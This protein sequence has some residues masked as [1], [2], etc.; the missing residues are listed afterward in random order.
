MDSSP[1]L[2]DDIW[3]DYFSHLSLN[4]N[5]NIEKE[6]Q[7]CK[8][9]KN[10]TLYTINGDIFLENNSNLSRIYPNDIIYS[11]QLVNG[12][13]PENLLT[14]NV[15]KLL[16][17]NKMENVGMKILN[18]NNNNILFVNTW[19]KSSILNHDEYDISSSIISYK[20]LIST[21]NFNFNCSLSFVIDNPKQLI[22][23]KYNFIDNLKKDIKQIDEETIF[24]FNF[25]P[26]SLPYNIEILNNFIINLSVNNKIILSYYNHLFEGNKNIK[27]IDKDYGITPIPSCKNLLDIWDIAIKCKKIII[28][29]SG[30]SWTFLHKLKEIKSDQIY[31]FNDTN[32]YKILNNCINTLTEENKNLINF[33]R[34]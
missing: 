12:D 29:P 22:E 4:D 5:K 6:I 14:N 34:F 11:N 13:P 31:M 24:I 21:I 1:E 7:K 17:D 9:C 3:A 18:F 20:N 23:N 26:R 8:N 25:T 10:E 16:L 28:L 30:G 33:F 2:I 32:Y 27:F 19:C 15:L